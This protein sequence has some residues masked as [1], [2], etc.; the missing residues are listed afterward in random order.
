MGVLSSL[1]HLCPEGVVS[2]SISFGDS[3]FEDT[4]QE[5]T[6]RMELAKAGFLRPEKLLE[7]YFDVDENAAKALCPAPESGVGT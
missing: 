4:Q 1:Y 6:R 5:F 7:W 3:V 2:P